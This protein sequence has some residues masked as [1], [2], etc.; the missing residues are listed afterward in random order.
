[1]VMVAA[2]S[3]FSKCE[4]YRHQ[5]RALKWDEFAGFWLI[6]SLS[7]SKME[8]KESFMTNLFEK[9]WDY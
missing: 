8:K 7:L 9:N 5:N 4:I 2:V 6:P 1:M 3:S